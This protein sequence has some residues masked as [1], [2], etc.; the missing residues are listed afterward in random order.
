MRGMVGDVRFDGGHVPPVH[1]AL[2]VL[3]DQPAPPVLE[4]HGRLERSRRAPICQLIR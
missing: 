1:T 2:E 4:V 3:C